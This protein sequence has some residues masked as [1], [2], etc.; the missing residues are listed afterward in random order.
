MIYPKDPS[1]KINYYPQTYLL[2]ITIFSISWRDICSFWIIFMIAFLHTN[3]INYEVLINIK[4]SLKSYLN[5]LNFWLFKVTHIC[6]RLLEHEG[7]T[8]TIWLRQ[9]DFVGRNVRVMTS[10]GSCLCDIWRIVHLEDFLLLSDVLLF[11]IS[12]LVSNHFEILDLSLRSWWQAFFHSLFSLLVVTLKLIS[13]LLVFDDVGLAHRQL[14]YGRL[15]LTREISQT[16]LK[17]VY[18]LWNL[19]SRLSTIH[20]VFFKLFAQVGDL[21]QN[22]LFLQ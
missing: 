3:I 22:Q 1:M 16:W 10:L 18:F 9:T 7:R 15:H 17:F 2:K 5:F 11:L 13:L 12:L 20:S 21:V 6:S 14:W 4:I 19:Q 8:V